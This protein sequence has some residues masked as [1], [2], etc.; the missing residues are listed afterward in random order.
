MLDR[1]D[2]RELLA[3]LAAFLHAEVLPAVDGPLAHRVR[4]A[5]SVLEGLERES[6]LGTGVRVRQRQRLCELLGLGTEDLLPG[7]L[8]DQ[9]ADLEQQVVAE[10]EAGTWPPE[11]QR[12]LVEVLDAGLR[13]ALA[14]TRPGYER[15]RSAP[16]GDAGTNEAPDR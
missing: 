2:A 5:I 14:V 3:T 8:A 11:R 6:R 13:D 10:I 9:V 12:A 15:D 1:P 16:P 7:A 4:V